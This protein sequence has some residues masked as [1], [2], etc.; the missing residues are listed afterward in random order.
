M[1][2]EDR[3]ELRWP[4]KR[5]A[6]APA[7]PTLALEVE[8][9]V[10]DDGPRDLLICADNLLAMQA[11]LA[12]HAGAVDLVYLDPPFAT[13]HDFVRTSFTGPDGEGR[14]ELRAHAYHD[15]WPGGLAAFLCMLEPRLRLCHRLLAAHGSLYLHVDPTVGHYAKV[16][17]DEV[18][19]PGCFQREIV[20]R[21]GW[22]S[23]FKTRANNWIRNHDLIFFYTKDPTRFVFNKQYVAHPAGYR[24]R[25]GKP[26]EGPGTPMEDVWN[27]NSAEFA[28]RGRDSLDSI[29]IKSFSREKTGWATQ[30][31][32]SL[33]RRIVAASSRP[34]DLVADFFCGSGTTL[35]AAAELGRRFIGCDCALPAIELAH[36]RLLALRAGEATDAAVRGDRPTS[37]AEGA[38]TT[39]PADMSGGTAAPALQDMSERMAV[40][41][42]TDMS[43]GTAGHDPQD[44]SGGP[45]PDGGADTSGAPAAAARVAFDRCG[46]GLAE[47]RVWLGDGGAG[48]HTARLLRHHGAAALADPRALHGVR[49][50]LGV[51]VGPWDAPVGRDAV[52]AALAEAAERRLAGVDVLA[53]SWSFAADE[54]LAP[55]TGLA[56]TCLQ[57]RRDLLDERALAREGAALGERPAFAFAWREPAPRVVALELCGATLR[58]PERLDPGL[59]A[60]LAEWSELVEGWSV[61]FAAT[62]G[63]LRADTRHFRTRGQRSLGRV[64]GPFA[65]AGPGPF[66]ARI[67]VVDRL[68]A[69]H[70][71]A[72][73]LTWPEGQLDVA[74]TAA[75]GP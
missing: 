42:P 39:V 24:R 7:V 23:G 50:E 9:R 31:N 40:A 30:K 28:L 32:A 57:I 47:R 54:D 41:V 44:M 38:A 68:G 49:G 56:L 61:E 27:A 36:A 70:P 75:D 19:G 8:Q 13:G 2:R 15:R 64:A 72:F 74:P 21:I 26:A 34:G 35:V 6:G 65:Y 16:M 52:R 43:E 3:V 25:D 1:S 5:G 58:R 17:L 18:F 37:T 45:G 20:W 12:T 69:A 63:P 33:L 67:E 11:L 53:W 71:L 55:G 10:G 62:G 48:E 73:R 46:L 66:V 29:Q 60:A 22:L 14:G 4:G 59:R 51:L